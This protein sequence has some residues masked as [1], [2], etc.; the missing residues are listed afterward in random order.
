MFEQLEKWDQDL[1]LFLNGLHVDWL[2]WPMVLI[3]EP[4]AWIPV[5]LLFFYWVFKHQKTAKRIAITVLGLALTITIA[6]MVSYRV[7]KKG[8]KRYRPSHNT[9][10]G[11]KTHVLP[12]LDGEIYT[13]GKYGFVSGH[14]ANYFGIA[15]FM[16]L[17]T[18]RKRKRTWL[19]LWAALI[20]YS[21]IYLGVHYPGDIVGGML[22]GL[23][24][25][26]LSYFIADYFVRRFNL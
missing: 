26:S 12:G 24:G 8:V 13:G 25:A 7:F 5:Y 22:I 14:S 9:I 17:A 2:D 3:S 15:L 23:G 20:A 18:G 10:I 19:F 6:D 11:P 1:F 21:R 16:F 4:L